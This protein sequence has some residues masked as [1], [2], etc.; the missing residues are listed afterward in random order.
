MK[1]TVSSVIVCLISCSF[2]LHTASAKWSHA[3]VVYNDNTYI[4][5]N[6][7]IELSNIGK[8]IGEV[9]KYSDREGTYSGNFSNE[10]P[11]GTHYY[12]IKGVNTKEAIAIKES[13]S[14]FI[15]GEFDGTYAGSSE[16]DHTAI[17][18][19][20]VV[21]YFFAAVLVGSVIYLVKKNSFTNKKQ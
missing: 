8:K 11:K 3:L 19:K 18:F 13:K 14:S 20:I 6:T 5:S 17:T 15:Q 16:G 1:K 7:H 2:L 21:I 10:F 9:T 4:V 12:E